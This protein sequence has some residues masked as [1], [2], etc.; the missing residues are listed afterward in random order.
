MEVP[1][2]PPRECK[3]DD[4]LALTHEIGE[5]DL[6]LVEF[7]VAG[8]LSGQRNQVSIG[9]QAGRLRGLRNIDNVF[10]FDVIRPA[11]LE[12]VPSSLG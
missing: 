6:K 1:Q 10:R 9:R 12:D 11:P 8:E 5:G 2:S 3:D 7:R 4:A